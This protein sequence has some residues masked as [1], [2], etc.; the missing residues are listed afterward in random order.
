MLF[1]PLDLREKKTAQRLRE[2]PIQIYIE[3]ER[4]RGIDIIVVR[5]IGED[6]EGELRRHILLVS[7]F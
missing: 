7:K 4:E 6:K 1:F 5:F 2:K 3:R